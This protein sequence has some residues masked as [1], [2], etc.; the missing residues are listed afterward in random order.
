MQIELIQP[1]DDHPSVYRETILERAM[2]FII[3]PCRP[4]F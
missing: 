3:W 1:L 4:R 2:A